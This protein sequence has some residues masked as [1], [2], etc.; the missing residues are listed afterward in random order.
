MRTKL[1]LLLFIILLSFSCCGTKQQKSQEVSTQ[2]DSV[3]TESDMDG[4]PD[5]QDEEPNTPPEE[6]M[7]LQDMVIESPAET[8]SSGMI[9]THP[10]VSNSTQS[11]TSPMVVIRPRITVPKYEMGKFLYEIPNEMVKL[12]TYT[13]RARISRSLVNVTIYRDIVPVMDTV[14]RTSKTMQV[15][16]IDPSGENFKIVSQ[17]A[18]Q[19][20][21][22]D[23]PTE[24]VFFVTPLNYGESKLSIVV[25]IIKDG[26]L[27]QT[28]YNGDVIVKTTT[29]LEIKIWFG[30]YW[31]WFTVVLLIPLIKWIQNKLS[32]KEKS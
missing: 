21:E 28:V 19:F 9:I 8:I 1:T 26:E 24:W 6:E 32:K 31:Q 10:H 27:K 5:Y 30:N 29:W 12:E 13:V 4:V 20:I 23:E 16:L 25:S 18:K 22:I 14:I 7:I 17:S 15:E 11:H 2:T 3:I